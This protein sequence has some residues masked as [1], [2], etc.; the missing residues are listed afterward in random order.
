MSCGREHRGTYVPD[1]VQSVRAA[2]GGDP[3]ARLRGAIELLCLETT[4]DVAQVN[5]IRPGGEHVE[6]ANVGH[7]EAVAA[8]YR[9]ARFTAR[10]M[11]FR[12]QRRR[13]DAM[14]SWEDIPGFP[15]SYSARSVLRPSGFNNGMSTLLAD[16]QGRIVAVCNVNS[17]SEHISDQTKS[18]LAAL[19]PTLATLAVDASRYLSLGLSARE[20]EVLKLVAV[21]LSNREIAEALFVSPRTVSTHVE[22]V[23][24]KLDVTSR[25]QA[26]TLAVRAGL[27]PDQ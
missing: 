9:S 6:V 16:R 7:E 21:G 20:R 24:A 11:G 8:Y 25:V 2:T 18:T 1:F 17:V 3:V 14:L 12:T 26:A 10:C 4:L 22:H 23:L 19:R 13:P 27:V 15:D 5:V